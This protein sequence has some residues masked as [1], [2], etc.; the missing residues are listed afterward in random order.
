MS[1]DIGHSVRNVVM[2]LVGFVVILAVMAGFSSSLENSSDELTGQSAVWGNIVNIFAKGGILY[3][4]LGA[5]V[6]VG[7]IFAA[8]KIFK[9]GR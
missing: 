2:V 4:I 7:L 3:T 1:L 6:L 9:S 8:F 5:A